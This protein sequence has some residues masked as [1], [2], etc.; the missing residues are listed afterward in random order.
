[1]VYGKPLT[2][3]TRAA[4]EKTVLEMAKGMQAEGKLR[5]HPDSLLPHVRAVL[6][7][8]YQLEDEGHARSLARIALQNWH[9]VFASE[10]NRMHFGQLTEIFGKSR[11]KPD[12]GSIRIKDLKHPVFSRFETLKRIINEQKIDKS[13]KE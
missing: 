6:S 13:K 4:A 11:K 12:F 10:S 5:P 7:E 9:T 1:M 3:A 2:R 8:I